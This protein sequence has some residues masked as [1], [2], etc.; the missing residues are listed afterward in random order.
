ME[1]TGERYLPELA[2]LEISYEHWHR[3]LYASLFARD[4][5]VLDIACGEGY[6]SYQLSQE[7]A[8]VLGVDQDQEVIREAAGRYSRANLEFKAGGA[9]SIPVE[10]G[11]KFD[12]VVSFETIEH[13]T[14]GEQL[15]FLSEV[16]RLMSPDG[17]FIVST[18]NK[19]AYSDLAHYQNPFHKKE[20][21]IAEFEAFL[22]DRF[23]YVTI[24]GHKIFP[25]SYIWGLDDRQRQLTE[26]QVDYQLGRF[27]PSLKPKEA[28]YV[29][30]LCSNHKSPD[31]N[32]SILVDINERIQALN[33][34]LVPSLEKDVRELNALLRDRN[35][36][37]K[38][39]NAALL[40]RDD[41][42]GRL[43]E[44]LRERDH[45]LSL[46]QR[47]LNLIRTS[48]FYKIWHSYNHLK[49][50]IMPPKTRRRG[51]YDRIL[52][53]IKL[54][55]KDFRHQGVMWEYASQSRYLSL[56]YPYV[57]MILT[58]R[59][60]ALITRTYFLFRNKHGSFLK[61]GRREK[62]S[63]FVSVVIPCYNHAD[64]FEQ[65]IESVL[66]QTYSKLELVIVDDCS[67]DP[68]VRGILGKYSS[69]P[70]VKIIYN[71]GNIG[72]SA[73]LNRG[74]LESSGEY[75][76]FLD[77]DDYLAEDA[78]EQVVSYLSQEP[79]AEFVFSDR[80]HVDEA[81]G[82][83][84]KITYG[85]R[86]DLISK[87]HDDNLLQE[88]V[89][90]HLKTVR[91]SAFLKIGLFNPAASGCQ[92]Y[93]LALRLSEKCKLG[94]LPRF[95]YYHRWHEDS[96]TLKYN[97]HQ[98][99]LSREIVQSA[100]QRRYL[101]Q[102]REMRT[103]HLPGDKIRVLFIINSVVIG[104]AEEVVYQ[105][106]KGLPHE[107][108]LPVVI[109][110]RTGG[111][112]KARFE[113]VCALHI[114]DEKT[115]DRD[116]QLKFIHDF[117]VQQRIDIV[118]ISN[119]EEGYR[120]LDS[121]WRLYPR[122]K[123][124]DIMHSD[125]SGF[126]S[127]SR[128]YRHKIDRRIAVNDATQRALVEIG[129]ENPDKIRVI[130]NG[131][132]C[133]AFDP[134]PHDVPNESNP[135]HAGRSP[136]V[137]T[138]ISRLTPEKRPQFFIEIARE[139]Q[140]SSQDVIFW[141]IGDGELKEDLERT[142][143]NYRLESKIILQG[144][145]DD[146][147]ACLAAS[148]VFVLT[149]ETEGT[150][151]SVLEAMAMGVPVVAPR[152]GGLP[153]IIRHREN[154]F[155]CDPNDKKQFVASILELLSDKALKESI[156]TCARRDAR[157]KYDSRISVKQYHETY[158]DLLAKNGI[159]DGA[160]R[161]ISLVILSYNRT[162]DL[163]RCIRSLFAFTRLPFELIVWDNGSRP[164]TVDY[165]KS[166]EADCKAKVFYSP[167]NLGCSRGRKEAL[168]QAQGDYVITVDNDMEFTD[169][170]LEELILSVESDPAIGAVCLKSLFP[171]G[172]VEF[173]GGSMAVDGDFVTYDLWDRD[174][175]AQD[176]SNLE[177]HGCDWIPGGAM[178][179]KRAVLDRVDHCA[180]YIGPYEDNDYSM[181]I[182][183]L[184]CRMVA[185]PKAVL[186]HHHHG[187]M[188]S[189]NKAKEKDYLEARTNEENL[190][191]SLGTFYKRWNLIINNPDL[192]G[193]YGL[194]GQ[195]AIIEFLNRHQHADP[196]RQ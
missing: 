8:H 174:K 183:K 26:F 24:L 144:W 180:D 135:S 111:A 2:S 79:E 9:A 175:Q 83:L 106:V 67:S 167:E 105:L 158:A 141:I 182:R 101:D 148:D 58:P 100:V 11:Q 66:R 3:Y 138:Y 89:A 133:A 99:K 92:D 115:Y 4:K 13:L 181:Q 150:P 191:R 156:S 125:K 128:D 22:L 72:I 97:P 60:R 70:R 51:A 19:L 48:L 63:P 86:P 109:T 14:E 121:L 16:Q 71:S 143:N 80:I 38:T 146:L 123:I 82:V 163:R 169:N 145:R 139:V 140:A 134:T 188:T 90:S 36:Q 1:F 54:L 152:I 93:D 84:E 49:D 44:S 45:S 74:L 30:A 57:R 165:L 73:T 192:F 153:E 195:D 193:K 61:K 120:A 91:R 5:T 103:P 20:F 64:Y 94:Y 168:K 184:N 151:L 177:V 126:I 55:K 129:K 185:A 69:R 172:T 27:A 29:V 137:V 161:K 15:L 47:D 88:M 187:F 113:E 37:I 194:I 40:E 147:P 189:K 53:R 35:E 136:K 81:G 17:L 118:H 46:L 164:D 31:C 159:L 124:L 78:I 62:Y 178:L 104:G 149:S 87:T 95:L 65:C 116:S 130:Y 110:T 170:W 59:A 108:Y 6:G 122:P 12:L 10:E 131:V 102:I 56:V 107:R 18:P 112:W 160:F 33:A 39:F 21:Y 117:V 127:F 166:L 154:G 34:Q 43:K 179:V 173:N 162:E 196:V 50:A 96:I 41:R 171:N 77:C 25:V 85:G 98:Q 186:I 119:S 7:A 157:E 76:S 114:L 23:R 142:I 68:R 42:L 75:I 132:D 32:A 155:L 190:I 52:N 176:I 28:L